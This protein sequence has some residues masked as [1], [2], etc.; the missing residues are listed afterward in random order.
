MDDPYTV[1]HILWT[2]YSW[3]SPLTLLAN[4]NAD[5]PEMDPDQ[6]HAN[7]SANCMMVC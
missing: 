3:T 1:Q 7:A 5:Y 6:N 2:G 4:F